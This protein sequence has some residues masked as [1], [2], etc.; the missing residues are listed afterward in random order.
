MIRRF[1]LACAV[2]SLTLVSADAG[3]GKELEGE[4]KAIVIEQGGK[5]VPDAALKTITV[6]IKGD[7]FTLKNQEKVVEMATLTVDGTKTPRQLTLTPVQGPRKGKAHPGIYTVEK[8][9]L[10]ICWALPG[11]DRPT[12]F[13]TTAESGNFLIVLQSAKP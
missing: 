4:W 8:G 13:T 2:T 10:K 6:V 12:E 11:K 7:T 3:D 9:N 5:K 1:L